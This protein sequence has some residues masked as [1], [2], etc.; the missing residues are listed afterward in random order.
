[1]NLLFK[2][3]QLQTSMGVIFLALV[4]GEPRVLNLKEMLYYYLEHQ[5]EV[6]SRKTQF[7]LNKAREREHI[8]RGLVIALANIDEVIRIIKNSHDKQDACEKL[9]ENFE[10]DEIQANAI[11]EMKL[12]RLTSLEVEKL[13]EE[14]A[15]LEATIKDLEDIL[16]NPYRILQILRDNFEQIKNDFGDE[17]RTE[18]SLDAGGID[19]ADLIPE[20]D[21]V[22]SMTN[23][24]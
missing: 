14:L 2:H 13:N 18:I 12:S 7:D 9:I 21:V 6:L 15:S 11:L 1:M 24:G 10:L 4:N 20:E 5:K 17:R 22:I 8:V 23:Q 3:S 16:A 19:I